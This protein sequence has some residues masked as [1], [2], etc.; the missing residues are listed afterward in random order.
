[1]AVSALRN[2]RPKI[3]TRATKRPD[4]AKFSPSSTGIGKNSKGDVSVPSVNGKTR[5]VVGFRHGGYFVMGQ[6]KAS[7]KWSKP[8]ELSVRELKALY[9]GDAFA[10][11]IASAARIP[12]DNANRLQFAANGI[13]ELAQ[14]AM[15]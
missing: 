15:L 13:A 2:S 4:F 14:L 1:M 10:K 11:A 9:K 12:N 3:V 7:G 6:K 5:L 8:V